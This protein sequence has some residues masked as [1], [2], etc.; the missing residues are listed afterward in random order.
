MFDESQKPQVDPSLSL[1]DALKIKDAIKTEE[2]NSWHREADKIRATKILSIFA[3]GLQPPNVHQLAESTGT[4]NGT[5][6]DKVSEEEGISGAVIFKERDLGIELRRDITVSTKCLYT[7]STPSG[8]IESKDSYTTRVEDLTNPTN[9]EAEVATI[10]DAM[11]D[12]V[13]YGEAYYGGMH[14][15]LPVMG[16]RRDEHMANY[17]RHLNDAILR[18]RFANTILIVANIDQ[19]GVSSTDEINQTEYRLRGRS[20][21]P[22]KFLVVLVPEEL[23]DIVKSIKEQLGSSINIK[24]VGKKKAVVPIAHCKSVIEVPDYEDALR[25]LVEQ[26]QVPLFVHG[27]RLLDETD[28]ALQEH[29]DLRKQIVDYSKLLRM[30]RINPSSFT[31]NDLNPICQ[32]YGELFGEDF[33]REQF[34]S[35]P[36][37]RLT[38]E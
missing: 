12:G 3:N 25:E 22:D 20:V 35:L 32:T 7:I 18:R 36:G 33:L 30:S 34:K 6:L 16:E 37:Y 23:A 13:L 10:Q 38:L 17:T 14:S 19:V 27:V 28:I 15:I 11:I 21:T 4:R 5:V 26:S 8:Q 1:N 9:T 24:I 29:P 31:D 2:V